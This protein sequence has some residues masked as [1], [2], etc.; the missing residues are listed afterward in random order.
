M[1]REVRLVLQDRASGAR[2]SV[3]LVKY[4]NSTGAGAGAITWD[5][6]T[7]TNDQSPRAGDI[8]SWLIAS[9]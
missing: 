3:G 1:H 6:T 4:V 2:F 7:R 8:A 5:S 9:C